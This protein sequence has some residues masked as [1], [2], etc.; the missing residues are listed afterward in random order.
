ME[1]LQG[2]FWSLDPARTVKKFA[3]FSKVD[4][5]SPEA[6]RFAVLEDWANEGEPLPL[7]AARELIED[8]FGA[9]L[10]GKGEWRVA[11][12]AVTDAISVPLLSCTAAPGP[13][14]AGGKR[15]ARSRPG[16][17]VRP[18][19]HGRRVRSQPAARGAAPP[20]LTRLAAKAT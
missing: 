17:P 11:G 2:A 9:D 4:S 1:V 14:C 12:Q 6:R 8:F 18:R 16:N 19:R 3:D 20:S 10:P 15:A 5:E 7:P 13:H